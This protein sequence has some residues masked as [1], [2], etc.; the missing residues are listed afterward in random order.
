M[1][2]GFS[3]NRGTTGAAALW[4][5]ILC[6]ITAPSS[7]S[8]QTAD[9]VQPD[10]DPKDIAD[11]ATGATATTV[12]SPPAPTA[13]RIARFGRV[14]KANIRE[15][16]ELDPRLKKDWTEGNPALRP[17]KFVQDFAAVGYNPNI[18]WIRTG[19]D[20]TGNAGSPTHQWSTT[21]LKRALSVYA[22]VGPVTKHLSMWL[23]PTP[24]ATNHRSFFQ[25]WELL[26]GLLN[27]GSEKTLVQV[28]GGQSFFWQ[29]AG[30]A[31]ADRTITNTSPCVYNAFNGFNPS[32]PS[33]GIELS[34]TG[35]NWTTGK[36]FGY[37]QEPTGTSSDPN[38]TFRRGYGIGFSGEKLIG[39]TGIS[40]I[41]SNLTVGN[42]PAYNANP[43]N[44]TNL[45][46]TLLAMSMNQSLQQQADAAAQAAS[47]ADLDA[48]LDIGTALADGQAASQATIQG[49]GGF[50]N[51]QQVGLAQLLGTPITPIGRENSPF[52]YWATWIN[53]SIQDKKGNVRLNPSIGLCVFRQP[54][55]LDDPT[56]PETRS[57]GTG[58]TLDLVAI[59]VT[60]YWT[61]ILRF[62]Q[63]RPTD[64][65]HRNETSTF[66]IG[67]AID[68]HGANKS[69]I[70]ISLDY[71]LIAQ[72]GV[73][74]HHQFILGFWPIW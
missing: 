10:A 54:R 51:P 6:G 52:L 36:I 66:T 56:L 35:L 15:T 26:Q 46:A 53:K 34:A 19:G 27:Y 49:A 20:G 4:I 25:Q 23:Q 7:V 31:G 55:Y 50:I 57:T 63:F 73:A 28:R 60:S 45:Q 43:D 18:T 38:I 62:D 16:F 24:L 61:S 11:A 40:G 68:L 22:Y 44:Y 64:L 47:Q 29:N 70:R 5:V 59:P 9:G 58:L 42:S 2:S 17:I 41:Q 30:F 69:R 3:N 1:F 12:P 33:K 14:L 48:G 74:P 71:S 8:A 39:K 13:S 72:K 32:N 67:Q 65:T 37:W 21:Y